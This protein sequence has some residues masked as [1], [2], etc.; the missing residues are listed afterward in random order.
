MKPT[1]KKLAGLTLAF[2]AFFLTIGSMPAFCQS[3]SQIERVLNLNSNLERI[4]RDFEETG[5][6]PDDDSRALLLDGTVA[7]VTVVDE[8]EENFEAYIELASGKWTENEEIKLY[9]AFIRVYGSSF[10]PMLIATE[11]NPSTLSPGDQLIAIAILEGIMGDPIDGSDILLFDAMY[12]RSF[13]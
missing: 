3:L 13:R 2:F 8:T 11:E 4:I 10:F 9:R 5:S 12:M 6:L 1:T 7:S